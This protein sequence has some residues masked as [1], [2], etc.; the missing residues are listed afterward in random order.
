MEKH[1]I[2]ARRVSSIERQRNVMRVPMTGLQGSSFV[3][4]S[5]ELRASP[6]LLLI[7]DQGPSEQCHRGEGAFHER[8]NL[9][10]FVRGKC[11]QRCVVTSGRSATRPPG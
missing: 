6:E 10:F 8:K 4:F 11:K 7:A 9:A 5:S 3:V 2:D 1:V